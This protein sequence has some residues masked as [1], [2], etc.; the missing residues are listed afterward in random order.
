MLR[1]LLLCSTLLVGALSPPQAAADPAQREA[2]AI[3]LLDAMDAA[4]WE[5]ARRDF[6][7]EVAA[8]VTADR[9][10]ALWTGI[11]AQAGALVERGAARHDTRGDV[12]VVIIPLQFERLPLEAI[13][14]FDADA[15]ISGFRLMPAAAPPA[16]PQA[17]RRGESA[18]DIGPPGRVL[19]GVLSL[20]TGEGRFPAV[21]LVHG[22][23][24]NDR[25]QTVGPNK[26]FAEIAA[27]LAEAGIVVHRFDKRPLVHPGLFGGE[28]TVREEVID[29]VLLA[30]DA[31]RS[32]PA[33]DPARIHVLG[34]SLGAALAPRIAAEAPDLAGLVLMAAPAR[35]LQDIL[36][37]QLRH[38]AAADGD[39]DAN[40]QA[41]I[42]QAV[43]Q[44]DRL[45][46]RLAGEAV[47]GELPLGLPLAYWQDLAGYDPVAAAAA[48][49]QPLLILQ[50]GRDYQVTVEADFARWQAAFEGD[51]RARLVLMEPL[52]HLFQY[53]EGPSTPAEYQ[54]PAPVPAPVTDTIAAFIHG[55]L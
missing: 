42:D 14:A 27:A 33:V 52:N 23:G 10:S 43:A 11:P 12:P 6:N 47:E 7:D 51:A 36:V 39:I 45:H 1:T 34:L 5:G 46:R 29:D 55:R 19:P 49:P 30:I 13:V 18:L 16:P 53:G 41:M 54:R 24:P 3:A 25:D 2:R 15:R 9:L 44:R 8:A 31:L 21:V 17:L 48:L 4:D 50:G 37:D 28:F 26:P 35:P 40:E 38:L 22:S 20:P 32:H